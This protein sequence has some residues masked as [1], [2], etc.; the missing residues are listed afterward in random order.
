EDL[1]LAR[2]NALVSAEHFLFVLLERL[3][4][5]S[6]ASSNCLFTQVVAGHQVQV[7][8]RDLDVVPEDAIEAD[9]QR[10]DA[11]ARSLVVLHLRDDLTA[12]SADGF[13]LVECGVHTIPGKAPLAD[14]GGGLIEKRALDQIADVRQIVELGQQADQQR[15]LELAEEEP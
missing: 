3:R 1:E 10:R 15:R 4:R 13:E 12:R 11:S 8:F 7:G 9:L 5:E 2:Q 14:D 6:L